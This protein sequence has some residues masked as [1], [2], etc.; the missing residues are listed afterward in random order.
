MTG[1]DKIIDRI[2]SDAKDRA[3]DILESASKDCRAMAQEFADKAE[4]IRTDIESDAESRG[5]AIVSRA[6]SA[7]A[8]ERRSLLAATKAALIDEAFCAARAE[9]LDT[10]FGKY[11]EL[12]TALLTGALVEEA[13]NADQAIAFGDEVSEFDTYEVLMNEADR[14]AYG[15]AVVEGAK[16][17]ALRYIGAART[18]KVQLSH[19]VADIDGGLVLRYGNVETNCS[20]SMLM[21]EMRRSLEGRVA[22]ILFADAQS[23]AQ[24]EN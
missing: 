5:E 1:L 22:A 14:A 24:T 12:L 4:K 16:R 20:L 17:A 10:K 11:R 23:E 15:A 6:R 18:E 2:L 7:A 21:T 19:E 13:K 3:R 9:V 8:M